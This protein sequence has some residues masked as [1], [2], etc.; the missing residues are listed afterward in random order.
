MEAIA[1]RNRKEIEKEARI[2][3]ILE[4]AAILFS[5]RGFHEVKVDDIAERVGLSKGAIYLYFKNKEELFL[6]IILKKAKALHL[7]LQDTIDCKRDFVDCLKT[8][9]CAYLE[10]FSE[11]EP[12]YKIMHSEKARMDAESHFKLHDY[13]MEATLSMIELT[14]SLL[15]KGVEQNQLRNLNVSDANKALLGMMNAFIF[16]GI[17]S[18]NERDIQKEADAIIDLYLNGIQK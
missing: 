5:Q 11:N 2:N 18:P 6:S 7:R 10:F 3:D 1:Q 9:V 8:F 16:N 13:A 12:F 4:N 17:C 14:D 15:Q